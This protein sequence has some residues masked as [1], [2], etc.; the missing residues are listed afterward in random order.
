MTRLTDDEI[1]AGLAALPNWSPNQD[2]T[3]IS[4]SIELADFAA[5]LH[6]VNRIGQEAERRN[7]HPDIDIR[8]NTVTLTLSTHSE[9]GLTAQDLELAAQIDQLTHQ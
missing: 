2:R 6:L 8:W 3:A 7:H 9:G 5:A 1:S 4:T